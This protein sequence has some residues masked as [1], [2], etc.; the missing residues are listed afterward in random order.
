M[1][2]NHHMITQVTNGYY[3]PKTSLLFGL[4]KEYNMHVMIRD[5]I[6]A[7]TRTMTFI[8]ILIVSKP[9]HLLTNMLDSCV[10][11]L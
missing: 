9:C 5:L 10:S 8:V 4:T 11:K 2:R 7:Y 3:I 1:V 6:F